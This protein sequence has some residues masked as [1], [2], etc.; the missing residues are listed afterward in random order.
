MRVQKRVNKVVNY[1]GLRPMFDNTSA[2]EF[3]E[4]GPLYPPSPFGVHVLR[5]R[6]VLLSRTGAVVRAVTR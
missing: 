2:S 3:S 6:T 1:S 4:N 5:D